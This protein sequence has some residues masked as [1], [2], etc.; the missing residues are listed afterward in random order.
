MTEPTSV[1]PSSGNPSDPYAREAET[2]PRL[3]DEQVEAVSSFGTVEDLPDGT[4]LF[5][6]GERSVDFFLV[7]SGAVEIVDDGGAEDE[8]VTVHGE[9]QFTGE[10]DLLQDRKILVTG[11]T[12]GETTVARLDRPAFRRML[13]AEPDVATVVMRAFILRRAGFLAHDQAGVTLVGSPKDARTLRLGQ[14]M[15]RNGHPFLTVDVDDEQAAAEARSR[16]EGRG[17]TLEDCPVVLYGTDGALVDPTLTELAENLG[18]AEELDPQE[19]YDVGVVGAGPGGLA[20]A[21]YAASEGLSTV[22]LEEEAPGGQASTSSRIENY[23]GFPLGLSGQDLAARAQVQAQKFGARIVVPRHVRCLR[24]AETPG[25]DPYVLDLEDGASVRARTVVIA[26]GARY[27]RLRQLEDLE[28]FEGAGV[29]YAATAVEAALVGDGDV[30]VVGGGNSA[31]QAAIFLSRHAR[32]VHVLVR[33]DGL[34]SSMSSYLSDRV[35]A[36]SRISVHPHVE[37]RGLHGERF[38]EGV[39]VVNNSTDEE[40]TYDVSGLFLMLGAAPVTDW[41]DGAVATDEKGFVQTGPAIPEGAY[42]GEGEPTIFE[43]SL[44]GVYAVGDVGSASVKRVASAVGQ[45]SV[46]V[47]SVH[48]RLSA[49]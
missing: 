28:R 42:E 14:F 18:I 39:T 22:V 3:P 16:L 34:A 36:S 2:F 6:R 35:E 9:H 38:L 43:T 10:L 7:L 37:V 12:R 5:T 24:K 47:S 8:V 33:G 15:S 49:A 48:E 41:L 32:H 31:G 23:L 4:A 46:V 29:H 11:R 27:R 1:L 44:P 20:A 21:V 17:V 30:V 26:T 40:S 45:G 25:V 13:V 19:V